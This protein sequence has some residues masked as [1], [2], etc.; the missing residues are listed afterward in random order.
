MDRDEMDDRSTLPDGTPVLSLRRLAQT[1]ARAAEERCD[2]CGEPILAGHRHLLDLSTREALCACR[3]CVVLFDRSEAG[4][5]LRRL[6]PTRYRYLQDFAMTD[7]E[8][9]GL[10][11]PVSMAF[12]TRN[13]AAGRVT[14]LYPSPAGPTE[15]LLT[16]DTWDDLERRNPILREMEPDVEAL[17]VNRIRDARD[18]FLVPIDACYTLVGLIRAYW[19]G[20]SGGAEV[21]RRIDGHFAALKERCDSPGGAR[22]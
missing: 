4:G 1:A 19:R 3:A 7:A 14:A 10:R 22:A 11:I 17:L 21:W 13:T 12:F 5:S 16:L 9:E 20:L 2:L 8:W 18:H 15:S 6:I